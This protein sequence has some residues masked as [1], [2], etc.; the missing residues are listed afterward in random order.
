MPDGRQRMTYTVGTPPEIYEV[1]FHEIVDY[2]DSL[3]EIPDDVLTGVRPTLLNQLGGCYEIVFDLVS[4]IEHGRNFATPRSR[5]PHKLSTIIDQCIVNHYNRHKPYCYT[6]LAYNDVLSR[7]YRLVLWR[8]RLRFEDRLEKIHTH[9]EP[10]GR[11]YAI[12]FKT[13]KNA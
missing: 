13:K 5:N 3:L 1:Q 6:F 8:L 10:G 9:L 2:D 7:L 11:G 4:N 12:E